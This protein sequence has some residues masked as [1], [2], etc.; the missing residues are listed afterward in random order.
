MLSKNIWMQRTKSVIV[1]ALIESD[2]NKREFLRA[3]DKAKREVLDGL[4]RIQVLEAD[5]SRANDRVNELR[6][7]RAM[8]GHYQQGMIDA[9]KLA[10]GEDDVELEIPEAKELFD[11]RYMPSDTMGSYAISQIG[12]HTKKR[13]YG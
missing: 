3:G 5:L 12:E 2:E 4:H 13:Q 9:L 1:D 8:D 11:H 10:R 7:E 6:I